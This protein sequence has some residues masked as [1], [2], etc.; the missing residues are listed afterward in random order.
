MEHRLHAQQDW[1]YCCTGDRYL[2]DT[3]YVLVASST[4]ST[5]PPVFKDIIGIL[6]EWPSAFNGITDSAQAV[7][8][9]HVNATGVG[10]QNKRLPIGDSFGKLLLMHLLFVKQDGACRS[11]D[12]ISNP[13]QR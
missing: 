8:V 10:D 2:A 3:I 7:I 12:T 13:S 4:T 5:T 9:T 1:R 11:V 6:E